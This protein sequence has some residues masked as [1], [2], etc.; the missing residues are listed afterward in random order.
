MFVSFLEKIWLYLACS[1]TFL[2]VPFAVELISPE[3]LADY[4]TSNR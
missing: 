4:F 2:E 3:I 1:W